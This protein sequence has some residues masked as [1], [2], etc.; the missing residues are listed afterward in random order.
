MC[1]SESLIDFE[2]VEVDD[3]HRETARVALAL[4]GRLPE[5]VGEQHPVG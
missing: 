2:A 4:R 5:P 1:P 3:H